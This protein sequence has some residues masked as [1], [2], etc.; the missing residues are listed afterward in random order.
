MHGERYL[1]TL[2]ASGEGDLPQGIRLDV[3]GDF[4]FEEFQTGEPALCR[5][6]ILHFEN[7]SLTIQ[8]HGTRRWK[9]DLP[10]LEFDATN[11]ARSAAW[12]CVWDALNKRQ[13]H[14]EAEIIAEKLFRWDQLARAGVSRR[15]G[16]AMTDLLHVTRRYELTDTSAIHSL[17]GLGSG[18]TPSGDDLLVGYTAGLWC[19]VRDRR[20]RA[21]FLSHLGKTIIDL[22][23]NTND[24]SRTYLYH[25]VHGQVSSRLA[26][27]AE[28]ISHGQNSE[29]LLEVA[30][31]AMRVGHTSG[32]DAVTGMLVGLAAWE[33][34]D[35]LSI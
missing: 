19:T 5:D 18:L 7:H 23:P 8:L 17:I 24:I 11:P 20:E 10:A 6:G 26:D 29:R 33:G 31:A 15:V 35:L 9:C 22:S 2:L 34:N 14:S 3:P 1:L 32:M 30:E 4:S 28:A 13:R 12:T 21:Q 25:A 27:L 16:E